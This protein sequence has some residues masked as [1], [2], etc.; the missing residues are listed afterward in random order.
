MQ[1]K[2][3]FYIMNLYFY[4]VCDNGEGEVDFNLHHG[5]IITESQ[6]TKWYSEDLRDLF[7]ALWRCKP[8]THTHTHTHTQALW[9]GY[10]EPPRYSMNPVCSQN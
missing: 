8:L 2:K 3:S 5:E 4:P 6:T 7:A 10:V 9:T 1:G